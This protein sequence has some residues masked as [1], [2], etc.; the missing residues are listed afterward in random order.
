MIREFLEPSDPLSLTGRGR[1]SPMNWKFCQYFDRI[2]SPQ[3]F[4][5][6]FD[7]VTQEAQ[8]IAAGSIIRF[9]QETDLFVVLQ[10]HQTPAEA[11][12]A[13]TKTFQQAATLTRAETRAVMWADLKQVRI[14]TS[15]PD[16]FEFLSTVD[17]VNVKE[18]VFL[19][20]RTD[21]KVSVLGTV[22]D[23]QI[24]NDHDECLSSLVHHRKSLHSVVHWLSYNID[25]ITPFGYSKRLTDTFGFYL[26]D[27]TLR[28]GPRWLVPAI[29]FAS[30]RVDPRKL[31]ALANKD[32][33]FL[34]QNEVRFI[35]VPNNIDEK[36]QYVDASAH[37]TTVLT[38]RPLVDKL[39]LRLKPG[40]FSRQERQV[41]LSADHGFGTKAFSL[42]STPFAPSIRVHPSVCLCV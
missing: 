16:G 6:V 5:V 15:Q 35:D 20:S 34:E 22:G 31:V 29:G 18:R 30:N 17:N 23:F 10:I 38:D 32:I 8:I 37:L 27:W 21:Q 36:L 3:G 33:A 9:D 7:E 12:F 14:R 40:K 24:E 25:E 2:T 19:D 4:H 13:A 41:Q 1:T 42:T 28:F 26:N 39:T 11:N